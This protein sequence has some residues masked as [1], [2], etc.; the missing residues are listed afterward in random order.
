MDI[1]ATIFILSS[2]IW[3]LVDRLKPLWAGLSWG[4][5]ITTGVVGVLAA[6]GIFTMELDALMGLGITTEITIFG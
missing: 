4:K 3:F 2:I 1:L 5:F 6:G